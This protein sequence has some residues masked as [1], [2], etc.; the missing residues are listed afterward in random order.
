MITDVVPEVYWTQVCGQIKNPIDCP[1]GALLDHTVGRLLAEIGETLGAHS[2]YAYQNIDA[3]SGEA[4][5]TVVPQWQRET[6]DILREALVLSLCLSSSQ[7]AFRI[8]WFPFGEPFNRCAMEDICMTA[9]T[10]DGAYVVIALSP[11]I[12]RFIEGV[13]HEF[14]S[15]AKVCLAPG[16]P[17]GTG[18]GGI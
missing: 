6:A 11:A 12:C 9:G 4:S 18:I 3:V 7:A 15:K 16:R 10:Q 17:Q 8:T 13:G 14:F 5:A 1:T 2:P